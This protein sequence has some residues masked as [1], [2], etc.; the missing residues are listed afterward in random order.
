MN[1]DLTGLQEI[2]FQ[3]ELDH[4]SLE[5]KKKKKLLKMFDLY[6]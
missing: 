1:T 2:L 3:L 4:L 6:L 5:K